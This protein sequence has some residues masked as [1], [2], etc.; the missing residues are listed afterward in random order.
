MQADKE[1][2]E[3]LIRWI[4][5]SYGFLLPRNIDIDGLQ[6]AHL[7]EQTYYTGPDSDGPINHAA[8]EFAARRRGVFC[9]TH[10]AYTYEGC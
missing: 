6:F 9:R 1:T 3:N 5:T 8:A 2:I 7:I 10:T 4:L